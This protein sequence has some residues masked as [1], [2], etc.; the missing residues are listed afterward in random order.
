MMNQTASGISVTLRDIHESDL[1]IL[2][3]HHLDKEANH[4]AAFTAKD[5]TNREAFMAHW[6]DLLADDTIIMQAI[7]ADRQVAGYILS[8]EITGQREVGYWLGKDHWGKGIATQA[9]IQFLEIIT[10]RPLYAHAAQDNAGSLRVLQKGGFKIIAEGVGF[11][12][13]RQTD[14]AEYILILE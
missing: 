9:L 3:A 11:S 4:M 13:A 1:P 5:P 6:A 2:F 12:N 14:V 7:V 10:T 8:F